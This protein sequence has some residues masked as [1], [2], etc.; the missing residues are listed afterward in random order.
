MVEVAKTLLEFI[1]VFLLIYVIYY[2]FYYRKI[3]KF[4]RKKAPV[5][6]KYMIYRYNLDVVKIGYK[7][8]F[9]VLMLCDSFIIAFIFT[10]TKMVDNIYLR[11]LIIFLL[12]FPVFVFVYHVVANYYLKKE[13][14]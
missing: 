11:F 10:I 7:R 4:D 9:K 12:I 14:Q 2:L 1:L 13:E 3:K 6:V 5:N 8:V